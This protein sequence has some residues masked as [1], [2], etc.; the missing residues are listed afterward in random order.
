M[1]VKYTDAVAFA[2]SS[3]LLGLEPAIGILLT[4][5]AINYVG[6][7][8]REYTDAKRWKKMFPDAER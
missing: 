6:P 8:Y 4:C 1:V 3:H 2:L 5:L 7:A